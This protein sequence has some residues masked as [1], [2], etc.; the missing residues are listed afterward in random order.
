MYYRWLKVCTISDA[1]PL[2]LIEDMLCRQGKNRVWTELDIKHGYQQMPLSPESQ[3]LTTMAILGKGLYQ[4]KVMPM[5]VRNGMPQ[6]Q[7]MM[8]WVLKDLPFADVYVDGVIIG[9]T[10]ETDQELLRESREIP[11]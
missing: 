9:S 4:W 6:C 10:G 2:P 5:G 11:R 3:P 7:R 8:E 1:F